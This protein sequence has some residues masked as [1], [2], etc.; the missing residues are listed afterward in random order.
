MGF[1]GDTWSSDYSSNRT[2]RSGAW[3]KGLRPNIPR[4]LGMAPTQSACR[5]RNTYISPFVPRFTW[6]VRGFK[7]QTLQFKGFRLVPYGC[8]SAFLDPFQGA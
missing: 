1:K 8:T 6:A 3:L 7:L 5:N 2:R 4:Q